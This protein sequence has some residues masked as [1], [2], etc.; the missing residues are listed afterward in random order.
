[1]IQSVAQV[2]ICQS[3]GGVFEIHTTQKFALW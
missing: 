2:I 1:M 3:S